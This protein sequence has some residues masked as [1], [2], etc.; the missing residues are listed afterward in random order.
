MMRM[1]GRHTAVIGTVLLLVLSSLACS[2]S[3]EVIN[4]PRR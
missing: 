1:Y 3:G 2:I 4:P